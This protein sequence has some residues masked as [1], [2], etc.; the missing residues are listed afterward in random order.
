[1]Y[2][3]CSRTRSMQTGLR[4]AVP[5]T[6]SITKNRIGVGRADG[7]SNREY[8]SEKTNRPHTR[9]SVALPT[10]ISEVCSRLRDC[11]RNRKS[12]HLLHIYTHAEGVEWTVMVAI[13]ARN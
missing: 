4:S 1:V 5:R 11:L 2:V 10:A 6:T 7:A 3:R 12:V 8:A 13:R 9:A